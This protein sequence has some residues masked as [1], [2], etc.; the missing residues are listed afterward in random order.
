MDMVVGRVG[1]VATEGCHMTSLDDASVFKPFFTRPRDRCLVSRTKGSTRL[2]FLA[3]QD[4]QHLSILVN[5]RPEMIIRGKGLQL[6]PRPGKSF[7][8]GQVAMC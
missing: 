5:I 7:V 2:M 6:L 3:E 4:N 8:S 1:Q